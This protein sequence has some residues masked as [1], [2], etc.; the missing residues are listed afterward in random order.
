MLKLDLLISFFQ[1]LRADGLR[2]DV[3]TYT[4]LL[5]ACARVGDIKS[6][7]ALFGKMEDE[8]IP[9]DGGAYTALVAAYESAGDWE[10][11]GM[12]FLVTFIDGHFRN[13]ASFCDVF[14]GYSEVATHIN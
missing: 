11:A 9:A 14:F 5:K 6:A 7:K 13:F 4:L 2:G 3:V 10:G 12:Q 1:G 8:K